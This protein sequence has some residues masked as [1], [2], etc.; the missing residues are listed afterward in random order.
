MES[1]GRIDRPVSE[2]GR[3]GHFVLNR[4]SMSLLRCFP[5]LF[6]LAATGALPAADRDFKSI[7]NGKDLTGWDG[8]PRFWSVQDGVLRG[9]TTLK[10]LALGNTFLIWRDGTLKDF[11]LKAKFRIRN[12]NSGIQYR[13]QDLGKWVVSGY[14][15]EI[16]NTPGKAGF[17]YHERGRKYLAIVGEM[18][19]IGEDGKPK[20]VGSLGDKQ[21]DFVEQRYYKEKDWNDYAIHAQGNHLEHYLNGIKTVDVADNDSKGRSMEGILALQIHAGPPMLVEFK[22]ILLKN[23]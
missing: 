7:F 11:E 12:G 23:H 14:Q 13:S 17:L 8:D 4:A 9:E 1:Q 2:A 21:K 18:V 5:W 15:A 16:D 19:E 6:A 22:D 3:G 10:A 20:V